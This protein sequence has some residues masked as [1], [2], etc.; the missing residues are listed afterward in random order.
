VSQS[1]LAVCMLES[2]YGNGN[3]LRIKEVEALNWRESKIQAVFFLSCFL[4]RVNLLKI[5]IVLIW[6]V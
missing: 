1:V 2:F 3:T 4:S 5:F 6:S